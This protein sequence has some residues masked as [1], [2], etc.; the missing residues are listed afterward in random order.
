[1]KPGIPI[2]ISAPSGAGKTTIV[3][4]IL[5]RIKGLK[6][7][8]STTTRPPSKNE[9][10]GR[11]YYFLSKKEFLN[12][13]KARKFIETA[14]VH[15]Y[16]YGT[17]KEKLDNNLKKGKDV[18]L[19]IDVKGALNVKKIYPESLLIF[20]IPP[21][22]KVL[23]DRLRKRHRDS[24]QEIKKRLKNAKMEMEYRKYYDYIVVN[25]SLEKAFN[26]IKNIIKERMT[27]D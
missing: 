6:Y 18:V 7:S 25:D 17:L 14:I 11:D 8:I 23:E 1:M 2:V 21:S 10:N 22:M 15:G 12:K 24:E 13:R 26:E 5:K 20:V 9:K 3:N 4:L 16:Y 27:N 19:N